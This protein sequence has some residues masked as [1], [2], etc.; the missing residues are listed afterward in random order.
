MTDMPDPAADQPEVLATITA[1][2]MRRLFGMATLMVLGGVLIYV[3]LT[4]SPALHWRLFLLVLGGLVLWLAEA[5][6]RATDNSIELTMEGMRSSNG[7]VIAPLE[8]IVEIRRGMFDLKPSN[9]F[10]VALKEPRSRKW[11]PGLW[12]AYGRRVGVGGVTPGS[13]AKAMAQII[14]ALLIERH[15]SEN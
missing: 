5:T 13:Q 14:E 9:G 7:D 11:Q 2:P 12:W 1:S 8:N 3:A 6:R 15:A 10:T 4:T